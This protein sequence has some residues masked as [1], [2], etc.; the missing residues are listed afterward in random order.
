MVKSRPIQREFCL[1]RRY[2]I[3]TND[4]FEEQEAILRELRRATTDVLMLRLAKIGVETKNTPTFNNRFGS[5]KD[6]AKIF[7]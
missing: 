2:D 4:T 3:P 1:K 7:R 6:H 5:Y